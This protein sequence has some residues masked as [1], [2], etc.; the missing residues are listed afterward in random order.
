MTARDGLQYRL[1]IADS[2]LEVAQQALAAGIWWLAGQQSQM[3][4]E[5]AAK[6][7]CAH[8]SA[9][10]RTHDAGRLLLALLET[11]QPS[12]EQAPV[13]AELAQLA[14]RYG[15]EAHA[16]FSYG[17]E[18]ELKGP[19]ELIS[20]DEAREAVADAARAVELVGL[21]RQADTE[22]S[23][24]TDSTAEGEPPARAPES[25]QGARA[26]EA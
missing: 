23:A 24:E 18:E 7:A 8:F 14:A 16:R 9:V 13:L 12:P 3:C 5:N 25:E 21:V 1:G 2:S 26:P 10:P 4:V 15:H 11:S 17:D 6:A 19:A 22:A 20:E